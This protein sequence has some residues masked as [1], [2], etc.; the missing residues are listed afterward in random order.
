MSSADERAPLFLDPRPPTPMPR[1]RE[2]RRGYDPLEVDRWVVNVSRRLEQLS[3]FAAD[4]E[5][6]LNQAELRAAAAHGRAEAAEAQ[7][8]A[9]EARAASRQVRGISARL[10]AALNTVLAEAGKATDAV[11]AEARA[12]AVSL[13]AAAQE[14]SELVVADAAVQGEV[15]AAHRRREIDDLLSERIA[16]QERLSGEVEVL[17]AAQ[18][19]AAGSARS[20]LDQ[21]GAV[22]AAL[23]QPSPSATQARVVIDLTEGSNPDG[24]RASG[25]PTPLPVQ[26]ASDLAG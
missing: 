2:V 24:V 1:F 23:D 5:A 10:D 26:Q 11:L 19:L 8:R 12:Q 15:A 14:Q 25:G 7:A 18:R 6:R 16:E 21:L 9:A 13:V 4:A 3:A 22:A 17:R 20:V